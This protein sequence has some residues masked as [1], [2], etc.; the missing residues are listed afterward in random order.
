MKPLFSRLALFRSICFTAVFLSAN[1][2]HLGAAETQNAVAETPNTAETPDVS[3]ATRETVATPSATPNAKSPDPAPTATPNA[4]PSPIEDSAWA[5]AW[6]RECLSR[7]KAA[8]KKYQI[9]VAA[10]DGW[11]FFAPELRH[12]GVG[13]FWGDAAAKTSR[14]TSPENADPLPAILDFKAQLDRLGIELLLVPVPP[15]A[16]IYPEVLMPQNALAALTDTSSTRSDIS[17]RLDTFHQQFYASLRQN[18]V[19]V[20]D[21]T[22]P[23]LR[24][25]FDAAGALYCRQDTHWSGRACVMAAREIANVVKDRAWLAKAREKSKP[26]WSTFW[27]RRTIEGDLWPGKIAGAPPAESLPLRFV[28]TATSSTRSVGGKSQ[29]VT[30]LKTLATQTSS[31]ILVLGDSHALVFSVGDDMHTRGAGLPDQLAF[32]LGLPV[33]LLAVRGSGATPSRSELRRR[34]R[35]NA[36]YLK[37]KKLIIWCFSAREWTETLGWQKVPLST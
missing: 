1:A 29:K 25:R 22:S 4:T 37:S 20:L 10:R 16:V 6:R 9:A 27:M 17:P 21:L 15:K 34:V 33:D 35:A 11:Y 14:A 28:G 24:H 36:N 13:K 23:F 12:V 3:G 7:A 18:G 32:E 5:Q 26:N 19:N 8:E 2:L 31:P 30:L